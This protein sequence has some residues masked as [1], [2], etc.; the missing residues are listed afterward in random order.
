MFQE[1]PEDLLA[2]VTG[3]IEQVQAVPKRIQDYS[4]KEIEAFPKLFDW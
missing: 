4:Q 2:N 3:Q 1:L